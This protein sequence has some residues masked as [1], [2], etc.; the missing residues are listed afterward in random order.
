LLRLVA[1]V[2]HNAAAGIGAGIVLS[3]TF[4]AVFA[5]LLPVLLFRMKLD[6]KVASGPVVLMIADILTITLYLSIAAMCLL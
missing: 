4:S 1:F 2:I 3:V 5:I 6:P